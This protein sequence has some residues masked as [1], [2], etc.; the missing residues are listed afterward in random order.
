MND[1]VY[2]APQSELI[3]SD[4]EDFVMASR[5]ARLGASTI[6]GLCMS[7]VT[8]PVMYFSGIFKIIFEGNEPAIEHTLAIGVFGFFVFFLINGVLLS[9]SGQTLGKKAV[10]IKV[11]DLDGSLPSLK[12]LILKRYSVYFLPGQ[13]PVVGQLFSML[14]ILMIFG[15]QKRCIHDYAAN[16][17]VVKV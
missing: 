16:T 7:I 5:W 1:S 14:N 15:K 4:N 3:E 11:V 2:D 8:L 17:K 13:I 9:R 10:G 12:Q 6:D